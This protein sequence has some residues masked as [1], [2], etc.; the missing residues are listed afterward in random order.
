M[1]GL[2]QLHPLLR[3]LC[4]WAGGQEG[5]EE[6]RRRQARLRSAASGRQRD[7]EMRR[8]GKGGREGEEQAPG[9]GVGERCTISHLS[10]RGLHP[11]D[12]PH[13]AAG[14]GE[15]GSPGGPGGARKGLTEPA[16]A[17]CAPEPGGVW[18]P[19]DGGL[20]DPQGGCLAPHRWFKVSGAVWVTITTTIIIIITQWSH[21]FCQ[22]GNHDNALNTL[23]VPPPLAPLLS[24][25][26]AGEGRGEGRSPSERRRCP[27]AGQA[28]GKKRLQTPLTHPHDLPPRDFPQQLLGG[29]E[30][31]AF[32]FVITS[33][34]KGRKAS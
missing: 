28:G 8:E 4:G 19:S 10:N 12:P 21:L 11:P 17:T 5:Q 26:S 13:R 15:P 34:F 22:G 6:S 14:L 20:L 16:A 33:S 31:T 30:P 27:R 9:L 23:A 18:L 7:R 2:E 29:E 32:T 1:G 25:G 3:P 24:P